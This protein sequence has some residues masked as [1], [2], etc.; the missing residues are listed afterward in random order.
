MQNEQ[1]AEYGV[2]NILDDETMMGRIVA[3]LSEIHIYEEAVSAKWLHMLALMLLV[4][5]EGLI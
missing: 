5:S 4:W 2:N 1:C 3:G